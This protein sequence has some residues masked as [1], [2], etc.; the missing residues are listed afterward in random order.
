M[1]ERASRGRRAH[2]RATRSCSTRGRASFARRFWN[3]DRGCLYDVVDVDHVPG[4]S[5]R[6]L[7]PNQILAVGG[8][9]FPLLRGEAARRVVDAVE[10]EL[11]TPLGLRSLEPGAPGYRPRYEGGVLSRDGAYHQGTVWPWLLG[12]V[13]RGVGTGPGGGGAVR[14]EARRRFVEPAP[15]TTSNSG[16]GARLGDRRR[17]RPA[18]AARLSVPGV[19]AGRSPPSRPSGPCHGIRRPRV[20]D[21][22]QDAGVRFRPE[23]AIEA[24]LLGTFMVSACGFVVLLEHPGSAV[25]QALPL[26][27][28]RRALMGLAMGSTAVALIYSSWGRR[29]GAHMNPATTLTFA[30]LGKVAPRDAVSYLVAQFVGGIVG[31]LVAS[32]AFGNLL[33]D[34]ATNYAATVPGPRG[35]AVAF[36]AETL[37]TFGLMWVILVVSNHPHRAHLTGVCAGLLVAFYIAV[38]APLSGMSMNP[39]RTLGSAVFAR[40]WTALWIYFTAPPLG[41][42]AAAELY[43]RRRGRNAVGCAKLCH[44]EPCLFCEWHRKGMSGG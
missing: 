6:S 40:D 31:V 42:L 16:R 14:A 21:D 18:R 34:R 30:R 2:R 39:A 4:R 1:A 37:I 22:G 27:G 28:M 8:L 12:P 13:R 26:P 17:R 19:V 36:T 24:A 10:R 5:M 23:Y 41:M 25:H 44:A 38:E 3:E 15:G 29:S 20:T 43:L 32:L 9:P 7:R 35:V 33:D 11:W